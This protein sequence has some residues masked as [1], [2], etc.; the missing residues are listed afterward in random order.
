MDYCDF[1][2]VLQRGTRRDTFAD[3]LDE[4]VPGP[5]NRH[6]ISESGQRK[7]I[8]TNG[9]FP[10]TENLS[11]VGDTEEQQARK[12]W[13]GCTT[14]QFRRKEICRSAGISRPAQIESQGLGRKT[15]QIAP[16]STPSTGLFHLPCIPQTLRTRLLTAHCRLT[17][18]L[19]G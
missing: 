19:P 15:P 14:S 7:L 18:T 10:L 13:R 3:R 1:Q 6:H 16:L 11:C 5:G 8:P 12:N 17:S 2:T 4:S 9:K